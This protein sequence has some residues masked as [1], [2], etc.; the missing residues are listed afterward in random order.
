M[1]LE[2]VEIMDRTM[3]GITRPFRCR[4]SDDQVYFVKGRHAG[5]RSLLCEWL[6]GHLAL[7]F[8]LPVPQ[9]AVVQASERLI[10]AHPEG[11]DL[12]SEPAFGSLAVG[13]CQELSVAHLSSVPLRLQ[14]DVLAFDWWVRNQDR[15]LTDINGNPNLLW[16]ASG[17]RLV[18]IDHNVAFDPEFE[19]DLFRD[20]HVFAGCFDDVFRDL[21]Q[22]A[23]YQARAAAA[24]ARWQ[25]ACQNA[26]KE[27]W[28]VDAEQTVPTDFNEAL[29]LGSLQRCT[30]EEFWRAP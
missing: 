24:L 16:D 9:F 21:V 25:H 10:R 11:D 4:C 22:I 28:F 30:T 20:L 14:R 15:T 23:A 5:N 19:A 29:I 26:P 6:A 1:T 13:Q 12:G 3:Q 7:E 18:V 2:I 27:W 17:S 8:D